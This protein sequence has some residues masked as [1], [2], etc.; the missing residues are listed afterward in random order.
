MTQIQSDTVSIAKEKLH[1]EN[2]PGKSF[3]SEQV[4]GQQVSKKFIYLHGGDIRGAAEASGRSTAEFLDFS[5]NINPLG[6]PPGVR[7]AIIESL[8]SSLNYPDPFCRRLRAAL[9]EKLGQPEGYILCGNGGADLIYRLVYAIRPKRALVTAQAFA[10]YEEAMN[11]TGTGI[12]FF[13]LGKTLEITAAYVD[14]LSAEHDIVFL[15]NPNNPTGI[16]TPRS[17]VKK[18]LDK[19]KALNVRVCLDECFLD[20]V[21]DYPL[22]PEEG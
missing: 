10:E 14:K 22:F 7:E 15:C 1:T 4:D 12:D 11:Q 5:A 8:D 16:L 2:E 6:M 21:K 19:A 9:S 17:V 18:L 3:E 20:F 13:P